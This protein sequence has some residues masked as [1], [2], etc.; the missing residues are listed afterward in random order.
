MYRTNAHAILDPPLPSLSSLFQHS[1]PKPIPP[2]TI[3]I[4]GHQRS[5]FGGRCGVVG[6]GE[7]HAFVAGGFFGEA[8]AAGLGFWLLAS[9]EGGEMGDVLLRWE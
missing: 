9:Y 1:R 8:D 4:L 2:H 3:P 5:T 6:G 7:E